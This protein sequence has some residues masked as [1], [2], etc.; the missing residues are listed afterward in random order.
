MRPIRAV[1]AFVFLGFADSSE[2]DEIAHFE[3]DQV[4]LRAADHD[5]RARAGQLRVSCDESPRTGRERRPSRTVLSF[6]GRSTPPQ[7]PPY[8]RCE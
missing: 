5:D 6:P 1:E 4:R 3:N 2:H 8:F 7:P